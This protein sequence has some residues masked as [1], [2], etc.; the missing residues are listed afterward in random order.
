MPSPILP[1]LYNPC[2]LPAYANRVAL[3]A[4]TGE[5]T[6]KVALEG[7]RGRAGQRRRPRAT[8]TLTL[9]IF[10]ML[11]TDLSLDEQQRKR[12]CQRE[13]LVAERPG[14]V[15]P[16]SSE[17][18][19]R[20]SSFQNR[21]TS[22]KRARGA[23]EGGTDRISISRRVAMLRTWIGAGP[24]WASVRATGRS[25]RVAKDILEGE[26]GGKGGEEV[27]DGARCPAA[28]G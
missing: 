26:G 24:A 11:R 7:N 16:S 18:G 6:C 9:V 21:P 15:R 12:D 27:K 14:P 17:H 13:L 2:G 28:A 8:S 4:S 23:A 1:S 19:A 22:S 20:P 5:A 25:V 10:S 3:P